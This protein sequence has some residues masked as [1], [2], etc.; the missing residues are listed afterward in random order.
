MKQNKEK[1]L[2]LRV[3]EDDFKDFSK[4]SEIMGLNN[5]QFLR[6]LVGVA[7]YQAR[8]NSDIA[9]GLPSNGKQVDDD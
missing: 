9:K 3:S 5:S 2:Q 8:Q 6:Q 4:L 1:T 7:L